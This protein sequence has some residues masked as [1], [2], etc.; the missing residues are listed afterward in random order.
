VIAGG[1]VN[2]NPLARRA[3]PFVEG[4]CPRRPA[5]RALKM[6]P[7]SVQTLPNQIVLA[8]YFLDLAFRIDSEDQ[9]TACP[10]L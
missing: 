7:I 10:G 4:D 5:P 6:I 8:R 1:I 3:A 2:D 9:H